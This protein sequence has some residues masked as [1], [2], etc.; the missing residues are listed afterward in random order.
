MK[1]NKETVTLAEEI[2]LVDNYIYILNVR[3]SGD[4]HY[5]KRI[6]EEV[7]GQLSRIQIPSMILQPIVE[8]C[9]NYG[10]RNIEW[11]GLVVLSV[12]ERENYVC[13]SIKD[14]G[15]GISKE[16]L[17]GIMNSQLKES[18]VSTDSNGV[19]LNN[20]IS[21]LQLFF[22]DEDAFEILSDGENLGT[23]VII[24]IPN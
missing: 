11:Q 7:K 9:I 8:N 6:E 15:I 4:I 3:F 12:Y 21:R 24:S 16:M 20:V 1:K 13:I 23:E 19:G 10:I 22:D 2:E 5:E 14:N 18:D 17:S